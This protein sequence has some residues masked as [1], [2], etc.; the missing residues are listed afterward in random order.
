[1]QVE[2]TLIVQVLLQEELF[3]DTVIFVGLAAAKLLNETGLDVVVLEARDRVGGRTLTA[4]VSIHK[5]VQ[6]TKSR[7]ICMFSN[8]TEHFY[9]NVEYL[10]R[11]KHLSVHK[12]I[13]YAV[14]C[15]MLH[16][17]SVILVEAEDFA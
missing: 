10:I 5:S 14:H 3:Q 1:M 17:V 4:H 15:I 6:C 8:S 16:L 13:L 9:R 11:S 12:T 7:Y 2:I